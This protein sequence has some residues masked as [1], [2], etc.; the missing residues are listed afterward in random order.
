MSAWQT[1]VQHVRNCSLCEPKLPLGARPVIQFHPHARILIAGQAPGIRVHRSG[2]PFDDPSGER[3]RAWLGVDK[4]DFYD[5]RQFAIL[6][7]GFCYPGTTSSGD[8]PPRPECADAWR[9]QLLEQLPHLQLTLA[10]GQYAQQWHAQQLT[11]IKLQRKLTER[12]KNWQ[13]WLEQGILPLPHPSP[14][15][16][17]WLAKNPWFEDEVLPELKAQIARWRGSQK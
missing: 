14:R 8:A 10:I 6:P 9:E 7:M 13:A 3:L 11:G 15:N 12:V 2:K 5:A 1:T 17:R 4:S 16:N